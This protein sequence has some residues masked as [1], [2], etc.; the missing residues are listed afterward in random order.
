[1]GWRSSTHRHPTST[2]IHEPQI[3]KSPKQTPKSNNENMKSNNNDT[4]RHACGMHA[5]MHAGRYAAGMLWDAMI[6]RCVLAK[7]LF[8]FL[9]SLCFMFYVFD[10]CLCFGVYW[11]CSW[12]MFISLYCLES[13]I[14]L[15]A[16]ESLELFM[17]WKCL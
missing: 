12:V 3:S 9:V 1:M 15:E 2:A 14:F 16:P 13:Y 11:N 10:V 5:G 4:M 8:M 6:W 7:E 17:Y